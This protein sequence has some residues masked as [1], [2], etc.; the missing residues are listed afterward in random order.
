MAK[1]RP[2]I[3]SLAETAWALMFDYLMTT[4][5]DRQRSLESRGLTPNDARAVW[6]LDAD[7]GRPIGA[8]ARDWGCDPSN[9]T[10][11]IDRLE[12]A[13]LANRRPSD[14]DR[15]V[16][17]VVLTDKGKAT[18]LELLKEYRIPP[19]SLARL[20]ETDLRALVKVLEKI[21]KI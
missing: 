21:S 3:E 14:S 18:K 16:K 4:S 13:G 5:P 10:F 1:L 15:R 20:G 7:E 19:A 8:L 11:I 17:L 6:S 9:A 2:S 12:R